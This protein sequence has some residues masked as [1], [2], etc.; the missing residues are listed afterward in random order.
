MCPTDAIVGAN[1]RMHTVIEAHCTGCDLCLPVCPV[2]CI[3]MEPVSGSLTG[4]Q[5]WSPE[6]AD[7]ARQRHAARQTRLAQ[8][9]RDRATRHWQEAQAQLADL[10]AHTHGLEGLAQGDPQAIQEA[11]R[12]RAIIGEKFVQIQEEI[13]ES[14]PY[15]DG[16]WILGQGTIYPDT[17]ESG[18]T[19]KADLI[20]THHNRVAGIQK[21]SRTN[22]SA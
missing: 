13:L 21:S 3:V 7:H 16:N 11:Q 4:W 10:P 8:R 17:I 5:A 9:E 20:K 19:A 1:K 15:M 22:S 6:Q 14:G 2:D 18:G 12:K